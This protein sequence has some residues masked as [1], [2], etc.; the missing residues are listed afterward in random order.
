MATDLTEILQLFENYVPFVTINST[1]LDVKRGDEE[2]NQSEV[3]GYINTILK[4]NDSGKAIVDKGRV[5]WT[6]RN[7][8][9]KTI[10]EE[11]DC[12]SLINLWDRMLMRQRVLLEMII[13][14]PFPE[15]EEEAA[16]TIWSEFVAEKGRDVVL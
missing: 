6:E 9:P 5:F 16:S 3:N 8:L 1:I 12:V 13:K 11:W 14:Q 10:S 7:Q 2:P 4:I 15:Q